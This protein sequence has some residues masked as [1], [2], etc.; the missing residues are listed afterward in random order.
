MFYEAGASHRQSHYQVPHMSEGAVLPPVSK[1]QELDGTF[2]RG[3]EITR[4]KRWRGKRSL[5]TNS[6][7]VKCIFEWLHSVGVHEFT[8]LTEG[9]MPDLIEAL[10]GTYESSTVSRK[11]ACFRVVCLEAA[12]AGLWKP[13]FEV[14]ATAITPKHTWYLTPEKATDLI[15]WVRGLA[16]SEDMADLIAWIVLTGVRVEEALRLR[17]KH[18]TL[19][20]HPKAKVPGTK[21]KNSVR[22]IPLS[23][24]AAGLIEGILTRLPEDPE[25]AIFVGTYTKYKLRWVACRM[26]LGET[27]TTCTLKGLRRS[28]AASM[29]DRE[30]PVEMISTIL[31]HTDLRTTMG[32]LRLVGNFMGERARKWL[33]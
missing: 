10:E 18:I 6:S 31:G 16:G 22:L 8:Q 27:D 17:R 12:K 21:T 32:Y 23:T 20:A 9:L 14:P 4:A 11:M 5:E 26:Y 33:D 7:A 24:L 30:M 13:D 1:V 2:E 19:G 3:L 29:V 28:F 25:A 15:K